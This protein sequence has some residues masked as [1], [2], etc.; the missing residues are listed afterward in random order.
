MDDSG[1]E[2]LNREEAKDAKEDQLREGRRGDLHEYS[3]WV[4]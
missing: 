2:F 3:E 1:R 4:D